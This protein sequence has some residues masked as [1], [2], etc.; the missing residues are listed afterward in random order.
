MTQFLAGVLF[1]LGMIASVFFCRFWRQTHDR[2]F[3]FFSLGFTLLAIHWA[4]L[5]ST[6]SAVVGHSWTY[7]LRLA[8]FTAIVIG[9]IDKN[10]RVRTRT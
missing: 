1:A 8:A 3:G 4:T 7:F 6:E 2:L 5:G 9:V 10:R